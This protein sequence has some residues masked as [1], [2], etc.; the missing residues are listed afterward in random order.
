MDK[1]I[2]YSALILDDDRVIMDSLKVALKQRGFATWATQ[3]QMEAIQF[4]KSHRPSVA[5]IDLEMPQMN[6]IEVINK[7]REI[8]PDIRVVVVTAYLDTYQQEVDDLKVRVVEKGSQTMR[9]LDKII[10]EELELSRQEYEALKK[11][12]RPKLKTRILFASNEED[13]CDFMRDIAIEEGLKAQSV[14][15]VDEALI[16]AATF[17]P[18]IFCTDLTMAKMHGDELIKK[19]K[20]SG[21]YPSIKI[22]VGMTGGDAAAH[23]RF[24]L[25]GAQEVLK[26]PFDLTSIINAMKYWV[27]I[28]KTLKD[29]N[30]NNVL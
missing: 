6:G 27:D 14:H 4:V 23:R 21:D 10:C 22:Y 20:G 19:M 25:A 26:K 24:L 29:L 30:S 18:E 1:K 2:A 17:K 13:I 5:C 16:Q 28:L 8:M 9:E 12:E 11:R 7:M 15:S 3:N